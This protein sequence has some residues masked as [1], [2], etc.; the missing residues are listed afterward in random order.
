MEGLAEGIEQ[1]I[2]QGERKK[3]LELARL[4]KSNGEKYDK[5][6]LYTGLS[7]EEIEAL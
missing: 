4:M 6:S 3:S 2:E 1:G 5:I 7:T